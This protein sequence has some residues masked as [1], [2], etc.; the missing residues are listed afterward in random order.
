[1]VPLLPGDERDQVRPGNRMILDKPPRRESFTRYVHEGRGFLTLVFPGR[2]VVRLMTCVLKVNKGGDNDDQLRG[3]L[4]IRLN[5]PQFILGR[6]QF[7]PESET[8][9]LDGTVIKSPSNAATR[10]LVSLTGE[11]QLRRIINKKI[12]TA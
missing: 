7:P 8:Y 3:Y 4:G 11:D 5:E 12:K 9:F 1:M 2:V 10:P 6:F